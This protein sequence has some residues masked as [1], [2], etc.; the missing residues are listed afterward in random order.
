LLNT[1][2]VF[3]SKGHILLSIHVS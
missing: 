1:Q 3:K 2:F